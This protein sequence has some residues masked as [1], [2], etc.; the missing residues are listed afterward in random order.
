MNKLI[1]SFFLLMTSLTY[2]VVYESM[3]I[4]DVEK[5]VD[6]DTLLIFDLD[7]TIMEPKQQLGT[8]QWFYYTIQRRIKQGMDKTEAL[9]ETLSHWMA[10]Q[11][12]TEV[13]LCQEGCQ[14]VIAQLQEKNI[15]IMGLTTRGL[16]LSQCTIRQLKSLGVDLSKTAPS[17]SEH[18]AL[19]PR[20][21]LYRGGIL[22]TA[23]TNKGTAFE[24]IIKDMG[25]TV[26]KVVFIN[27][28][29]S[30]ITELEVRVEEM[31]IPFVGLRYGVTDERVKNFSM[32]LADIQEEHFQN[33][34]SDE[35]AEEILMQRK[36]S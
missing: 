14:Q 26:R 24:K 17:Q 23:G 18:F 3:D 10:L 36:S 7:N 16:G 19:N 30:H 15:P 1:A 21:V 25:Y 9:E 35:K 31:G 12:I 29:R 28:K 2:G 33:I 11:N 13:Q 6:Q 22:F 20:S 5:H 27:D 32:E 34:M 4:A 8:D